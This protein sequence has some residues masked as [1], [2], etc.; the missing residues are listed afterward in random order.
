MSHEFSF[1]GW[2]NGSVVFISGQDFSK[3]ALVKTLTKNWE[4]I[5]KTWVL[6]RVTSCGLKFRIYSREAFLL[7]LFKCIRGL[8]RKMGLFPWIFRRI[9]HAHLAQVRNEAIRTAWHGMA[10]IRVWRLHPEMWGCKDLFHKMGWFGLGRNWESAL[11]SVSRTPSYE[12]QP[13]S[14]ESRRFNSIACLQVC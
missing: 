6:R 12:P 10:Y 5:A 14:S 4:S 9:F 2:Y 11:T 7:G 8:L 13:G 1:H 3:Y